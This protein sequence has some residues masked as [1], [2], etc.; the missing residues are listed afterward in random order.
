DGKDLLYAGTDPHGLV[1]RVNRRSGESFVLYNA[2]ESEVSALAL[3]RKGNLYAATSEP[4]DETGGPAQI[5][6][7]AE[8]A[9][10]P[11]GGTTGVPIPSEKP[12]EPKPPQVPD[13]NPGQPEPIPR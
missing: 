6:G 2:A 9:G 3:D 13:P 10:R 8:K 7:V 12:K 11:E 1:Y 5:P 4:R